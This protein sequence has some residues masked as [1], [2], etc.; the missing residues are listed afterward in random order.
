[1]QAAAARA[2]PPGESMPP[3]RLGAA[4]WMVLQLRN[5]YP[6]CSQKVTSFF[7]KETPKEGMLCMPH[8]SPTRQH[9]RAPLPPPWAGSWLVCLCGSRCTGDSP[10][11][12]R[13]APVSALAQ[14]H[15][16]FGCLGVTGARPGVPCPPA[17][18]PRKPPI[19]LCPPILCCL[20]DLV[21]PLGPDASPAAAPQSTDTLSTSLGELMRGGRAGTHRFPPT[22]PSAPQAFALP[23]Q[24]TSQPWEQP[25]CPAAGP[26]TGVSHLLGVPAWPRCAGQGAFWGQTELFP[27]HEWPLLLLFAPGTQGTL[28]FEDGGTR[29]LSSA[30]CHASQAHVQLSLMT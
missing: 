4:A 17:G 11:C 26:S 28:G 13:C 29:G 7:T 16:W 14:G 6:L 18:P 20:G 30:R 1:M 25:A 21:P 19:S 3:L 9:T 5:C 10:A 12:A 22:G 8:V 15:A 23:A 2:R 27:E 24:E